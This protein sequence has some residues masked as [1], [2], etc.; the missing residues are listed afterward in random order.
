MRRSRQ[1]HLTLLGRFK[2][3]VDGSEP[4][5]V[6]V[7]APRQR[8]LLTYL[9]LQPGCTETRE[10][11]ATVLWG[12]GSDQQARQSLRQSLLSLRKIFDVD[13][14]SPLRADRETVALATP[15][16]TIDV[17]AFQT[18]A[19]SDTV[20]DLD[21]AM[22]L[23]RGDLLDGH[24]GDDDTFEPWLQGERARL[25]S[26]A[27]TTFERSA[28]LHQAS[29]MGQPAAMH[30]AERWV[31]LDR[32]NETAQRMLIGLIFSARGPAA[33]LAHA[34]SVRQHVQTELDCG[35]EPATIAQIAAI[36]HQARSAQPEPLHRPARTPREMPENIV[37]FPPAPVVAR[38][39]LSDDAAPTAADVT[40]LART[41]TR[42]IR[43][44]LN[45]WTLAAGVAGLCVALLAL[46]YSFTL[47]SARFPTD[48]GT[49]APAALTDV[50]ARIDR[51]LDGRS[52]TPIVVLP[53]TTEVGE[54]AQT[55]LI[56]R[57]ISD[58]LIGHLSRVPSFRVI[59]RST[60]NQY[61]G[62]PIDSTALGTELGVR[63]GVEGN[64]RFAA[65]KI[66]IGIALIDLSTR[67]QVWADRYEYDENESQKVH[68]DIVRGLARQLHVQ[69][70]DVRANAPDEHSGNPSM[71]ETLFKAWAAL[72]QFAFVRGGHEAR[73][74]FEDVLRADPDNISALT[75]LGA[76]KV[77]A[78]MTRQTAESPAQLFEQ[79][80]ALLKRALALNHQASL[81]YY[82]LGMRAMA[83]GQ[84]DEALQFFARTLE[85]N[86]SYAPAYGNIGRV[87]LGRGQLEEALEQVLYAIR[88]SPKDHYLGSWSLTAG[89]IYL[90][91][92][93]D[94]EAERWLRQSVQ[95]MPNAGPSR[96][97]LAAFLTLKGDEA[98]AITQMSEWQRIHPQA[99]SAGMRKAFTGFAGSHERASK[100]LMNGLDRAFASVAAKG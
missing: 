89:R 78:A 24:S 86:P 52:V 56:A 16:I 33:A 92:G 25:K 36:E 34:H 35:L 15:Y 21:R 58:D 13:G 41:A 17:L 91:L 87:L 20:A 54:P 76:Y 7:S 28:R 72:N 4:N 30:A 84:S 42:A 49:R 12:N 97:A 85:L 14:L 95:V 63:Y 79:S 8:A 98:G 61:A 10:R 55:G 60:S 57:R 44:P 48:Q 11:L 93:H 81:P 29:N 39:A 74:L 73:Q 46:A 23:Y 99:S 45:R 9:A 26:L 1:L 6:Q 94:S 32:S 47:D 65:K 88:L 53:F 64:V 70:M 62:R 38:A 19:A 59:A 83:M 31:A 37:A 5:L 90:E 100:R 71:R 43:T 77:A 96:A 67:L 66:Q 27:A 18:L 3:V 68:H 69:I 40:P 51:G 82:F 2:A 80:E 50:A 75:G 22:M